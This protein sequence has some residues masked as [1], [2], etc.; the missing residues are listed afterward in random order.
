MDYLSALILIAIVLASVI[1]LLVFGKKHK[2]I[3]TLIEELGFKKPKLF[4]SYRIKFPFEEETFILDTSNYYR[5]HYVTLSIPL[6][7]SLSLNIRKTDDNYG[8]DDHDLSLVFAKEIKT[9]QEDFDRKFKIFSNK[10]RKTAQFLWHREVREIVEKI[11]NKGVNSIETNGKYL[12]VSIPIP[13]KTDIPSF[14]EIPLQLLKLKSLFKAHFLEEPQEV[15]ISSSFFFYLLFIIPIIFSIGQISLAIILS[16][17]RNNDF[18]PISFSRHLLITSMFYL[19]LI[20]LYLFYAYKF[21]ITRPGFIKKFFGN[22]ILSI[23][24]F[25]TGLPF[26]QSIN[27]YFDH[28][29]GRNEFY[30]VISKV[31]RKRSFILLLQKE[32]ESKKRKIKGTFDLLKFSLHPSTIKLSV[33]REEFL[34]AKPCQTHILV[35]VRDGALK[36]KWIQSYT[37]F[38]KKSSLKQKTTKKLFY[39]FKACKINKSIACYY[40]NFKITTS[41][42]YFPPLS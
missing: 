35:L 19:P 24:W 36:I 18:S 17:R 21:L 3:N 31:T 33:K 2:E 34:E 23:I 9:G 28:S 5:Y 32:E 25:I 8:L 7:T 10:E 11:F 6:K 27:G 13:K 41:L 12:T 39:P 14:Q 37:L 1:I 15:K 26:V 30:L 38:E 20:F 40:D 4:L 29:P 16:F 22:I 42:L